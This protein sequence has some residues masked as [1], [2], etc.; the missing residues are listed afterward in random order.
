VGD[1][2]GVRVEISQADVTNFDD[3][4]CYVSFTN[5]YE[6]TNYK[7]LGNLT[8]GPNGKSNDTYVAQGNLVWSEGG[9][10][11]IIFIPCHDAALI[12]EAEDDLGQPVTSIAGADQT[13][14]Q[15]YASDSERLTYVLVGFSVLMLQPILN[16]FLPRRPAQ[17]QEQEN[18]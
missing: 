1:T 2:I 14:N 17:D 11:Y 16:E 5:A 13:V 10:T 6:N 12:V 8:L 4:Y 9:D 7:I 15:Q 18:Q 3:I